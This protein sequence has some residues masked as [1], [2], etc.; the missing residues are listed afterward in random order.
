MP[1]ESTEKKH[2]LR[3]RVQNF[4]VPPALGYEPTGKDTMAV[5]AVGKYLSSLAGRRKQREAQGI[6]GETS[7]RDTNIDLPPPPGPYPL[8]LPSY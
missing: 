1:E 6:S 7:F 8:S 2:V 5:K 4:P 3:P